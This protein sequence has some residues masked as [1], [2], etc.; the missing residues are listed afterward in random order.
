MAAKNRQWMSCRDVSCSL[1]P[2]AV[3][4]HWHELISVAGNLF[5]SLHAVPFQVANVCLREVLGLG[6]TEDRRLPKHLDFVVAI[7]SLSGIFCLADVNDRLRTFLVLAEQKID[8]QQIE[9]LPQL[10]LGKI[11]PGNQYRLHNPRR[12][13]GDPNAVDEQHQVD[14]PFLGDLQRIWLPSPRFGGWG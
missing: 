3:V 7:E 8:P 4:L 10:A 13:L 11:A 12:D 1:S 14:T 6:D 5:R 9:F 2:S